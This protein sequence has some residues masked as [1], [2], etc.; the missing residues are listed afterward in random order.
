VDTGDPQPVSHHLGIANG[1]ERPLRTRSRQRRGHQ[2][3]G[4]LEEQAGGITI[5]IAHDDPAEG[6]RGRAVDPGECQGGGID[7][8]RMDIEAVQEDR[9]GVQ[10][11]QLAPF[12]RSIP[13]VGIESLAQDP[14][15]LRHAG[16]DLGQHLGPVPDASQLDPPPVQRPGSKVGVAVYKAGGDKGARQVVPG[17]RTGDPPGEF[18]R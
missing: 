13:V 5:G 17:Y 3:H 9:A 18:G 2:I 16:G 4:P 8:G 11:I 14:S 6:I 12:R 1:P 15:L 7:P 10:G